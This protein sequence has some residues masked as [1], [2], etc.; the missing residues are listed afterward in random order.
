[1]GINE[2]MHSILDAILNW[3]LYITVDKYCRYFAYGSSH[4]YLSL[5]KLIYW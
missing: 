4:D 3:K 5:M 1:M 2:Y